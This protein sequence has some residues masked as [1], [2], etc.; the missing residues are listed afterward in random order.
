MRVID[1]ERALELRKDFPLIDGSKGIYIDNAATTQ[2]ASCVLDAVRD[3]YLNANANPY[4]G[5][6]DLSVRATEAHESARRAAAEF[7]HAGRPEEIIFTRNATESLNLVAFSLS[8]LLLEPGDE[9]LITVF[10]HHSNMLPWQQAAKRHGAVLRYIEC[11]QDGTITE[12]NFRSMLTPETKI[13]SMA[14]VSNVLGRQYDI[15]KFAQ[16]AH[17][18]GSVFVADGAQSVP[19]IPV[20]VQDLD[21]DFLAFSGHKMYGPMGIGVL[22]GKM[23]YLEKMPPFLTGGEMIEYVR[24]DGATFA[25]V[26]HKFEAGTVNVGGAV[27]LEAAIR[28]IQSIGLD[29]ISQREEM[30][31]SYAMEKMTQIEGVHIL[32]SADPKEHTGILTF[33]LDDVHPHDVATILDADGIAVR[34][35]HHCAQPL[36]A[37]IKKADGRPVMATTRASFSFYNTKE[38]IDRFAA[39]LAQIRRKMGYGI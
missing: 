13:V 30:L 12:E 8:E 32:G 19:H 3:Y 39:S 18:N 24:R 4:R 10:E 15:K 7:I 35:G 37:F 27:G 1:E 20:D 29:A 25:E 5:V 2:K 17:E 36:M 31:A 11:E 38:E 9:I 23:E 16:I 33:T 28:Y 34:A 6:Y 14:Q 26:P 21:V 22:Y